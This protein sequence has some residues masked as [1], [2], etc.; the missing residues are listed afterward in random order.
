MS[1]NIKI[2]KTKDDKYLTLNNGLLMYDEN[3]SATN[4]TYVIPGVIK[5]TVEIESDDEVI[6]LDAIVL[7]T[8]VIDPVIDIK[9]SDKIVIF[10]NTVEKTKIKLNPLSEEIEVDNGEIRCNNLEPQNIK[11]GQNILG[12][13]GTYLGDVT[14]LSIDD[15]ILLVQGDFTSDED[16]LVLGTGIDKSDTLDINTQGN[17][18]VA[19]YQKVS[20]F[21][22]NLVP[23]NIKNDITIFGVKGIAEEYIEGVKKIS[24]ISI[25]ITKDFRYIDVYGTQ[26][27]YCYGEGEKTI[28]SPND[29]PLIIVDTTDENNFEV[30]SEN[31]SPENIA[32]GVAIL[33]VTGIY[34]NSIDGVVYTEEENNLSVVKLFDQI[35]I[36]G[37]QN[38]YCS[39]GNQKIYN[40]NGELLCIIEDGAIKEINNSQ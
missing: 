17:Y 2:L 10:N 32:K 28:F 6:E 16:T 30:L 27:I 19:D 8:D 35:Q 13:V 9:A 26:E 15:D 18:D 24:D 20:V 7:D 37:D 4:S 38:L 40:S 39:S 14:S 12:V 31:L 21:D 25:E 33:G 1:D 3:N 36:T 22:A 34:D 5:D 29:N 23:E 11:H